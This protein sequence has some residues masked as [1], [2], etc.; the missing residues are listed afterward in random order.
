M[1]MRVLTATLTILLAVA[2]MAPAA[3]AGRTDY[4]APLSHAQETHEVDAP[5]A[6]GM[7]TFWLEGTT[8]HYEIDVRH[9]TGPAIAAH[10]HAAAD[11]SANAGVGVW[12]CGPGPIGTPPCSGVTDGELVTGSVEV[13]TSLLADINAGKAYV[14]VHTSR[15]PAGEVRGQ[16]LDV[17][18]RR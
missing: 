18:G 1:R 13:G 7:A 11:R 9:L 17:G 5:G 14:N 15:H 8:L 2:L 16:I 4:R 12:L 10:I 3:A 6:G